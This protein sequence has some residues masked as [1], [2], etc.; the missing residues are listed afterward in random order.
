MVSL[1]QAKNGAARYIE[2]EFCRKL[3][4][5]QKWVFGAGAALLL[6]N[7]E[8]VVSK[9]RGNAVVE[10]MDIFAENGDV[11]IEKVYQYVKVEARKGSISFEAPIL[12]VVTMDESDVDK[13]YTYI[14][15]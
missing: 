5:W 15:G 11:D 8:S 14:V 7:L 2:T 10:M 3:N 9:L 6:E 12:G 4:G 13:L 1:A